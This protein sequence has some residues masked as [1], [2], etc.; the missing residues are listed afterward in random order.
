MRATITYERWNI[1]IEFTRRVL[2]WRA[3]ACNKQAFQT[4]GIEQIS[5][6][7]SFFK[8]IQRDIKKNRIECNFTIG[9]I[10]NRAAIQ[11]AQNELPHKNRHVYKLV[12]S[13]VVSFYRSYFMYFIQHMKCGIRKKYTHLLW[14]SW[15]N[16]GLDDGKDAKKHTF[17]FILTH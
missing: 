17:F 8:S 3:T 2:K 15:V 10:N 9:S 4:D 5:S 14:I 13:C 11:H 7:A 6:S 16:S 1:R 12:C